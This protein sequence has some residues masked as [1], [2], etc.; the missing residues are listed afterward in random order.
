[1]HTFLFAL[2]AASLVWIALEHAHLSRAVRRRPAPPPPPARYPPLTVVRPVKGLDVGAAENVRALLATDYP[3]PLEISFVFDDA[4][5]PAVPLVAERVAAHRA[6]HPGTAVRLLFAGRPP[7]GRTG[8]LHAMALGVA[9]AHG[10]LIAFS[11]SDTRPDRDLLRALVD[12][13]LATPGAADVFA[14]AIADAPAHTAGDVGYALMLNAWY[15]AVA[16]AAAGP[17][18]ELPFI[19]GQLMVFRRAA[20]EAI[21]GVECADGQLVDDMYLGRCAAAAGLYNV[22]SERPLHVVNDELRAGDFLRLMRRW[23]LFSRSGLPAALK[24]PGWIRGAAIWAALVA[25]VGAL[26]AGWIG[27]AGVAA[28]ALVA[29]CASDRALHRALGGAPLPLRFAWMSVGIA[30]LAPWVLISMRADHHV[31]WRGRDYALDGGAHLDA[32]SR[33]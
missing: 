13:L 8:K 20:L 18:R 28:A 2:A 10:E 7:H 31:D 16:I 15:G 5:D 29:V 33:P 24:L 19:M 4:Q 3:G 14:P 23:I 30:L 17:R 27:T 25:G 32:R 21:G 1:M 6:R 26:A 22:I 9:E 11:D 12:R